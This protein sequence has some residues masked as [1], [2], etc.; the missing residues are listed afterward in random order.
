MKFSD[1][2][3]VR[4]RTLKNPITC[5]GIALHSGAKV[6]LTLNPADP[7]TGIVFRRTDIKGGGATIAARWDNVV[8][9]RMC[10]MLGDENGVT[11]GTVE[12]L[13]A[14][15]AGCAIDN[16]LV[17]LNGPEVPIMD[18]SSEPF[19]FLIECAGVAEQNAP[20]RAIRINKPVVVEQGEKSAALIPGEGFAASVE[21]RFDNTV[22]GNQAMTLGLGDGVFKGELARA[23]TFGFV[24]EVQALWDAGLAKGGS[25][26]NA[27]VVNGD[28]VLNEEGLRWD[29]EF[30]RHKVL[31][32]VG[33][34]YL[35]GAPIIG[36]YHGVCSGHAQSNELLHALFAD[37]DAWSL[38]V[39][40]AAEMAAPMA[41]PETAASPVALVASA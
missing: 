15:L 2:K 14:A 41:V 33:D 31:D 25:L 28:H 4:Q 12:H 29:D 35:A 18:G 30:V 26:D 11:I 3:T 39:M 10:T 20:R 38:D 5:S 22:I 8:D 6:N 13:T 1:R 24:H 37:K 21:I 27:I 34:L 19:V 32:A 23:R 16:V 9:T 17:E 7:D 36:H 40:T